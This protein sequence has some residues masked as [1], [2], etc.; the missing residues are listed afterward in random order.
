M[1]KLGLTMQ[2]ARILEWY[3][4]EGEIVERG[5]PLLSV[6]SEKVTI[7]VESPAAGVLRRILVAEMSTADVG[8]TLAIISEPNEPLPNHDVL[9]PGS[10]VQQIAQQLRRTREQT[11]PQTERKLLV[12]PAA[13][14]LADEHHLDL[15]TVAIK[16]PAEIIRER[17]VIRMIGASSA[18]AQVIP[19]SA[20]RSTM[21]ER[22]SRSYSE[23]L[24][25]TLRV[26][27]DMS[28][29]VRFKEMVSQ[30]VGQT[31]PSYTDFMVKAVALSLRNHPLF[32]STFEDGHIKTF[33]QINIGIAV[34]AQNGVAVPVVRNADRKKLAEI[35]DETNM[36]IQRARQGKLEFDDVSGGTFTVTN[37]GMY[38]VD[39]FTPIINPPQVAILAA[40]RILDKPIAIQGQ[41]SIRPMVNLTLTFDHRIADGT[42]GAEFLQT[43]C[44]IL[45]DPHSLES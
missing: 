8:E 15:S 29:L 11:R 38:G 30:E 14:R 3:F 22:L 12:S 7:D 23:A 37:L 26:E 2:Q 18:T 33:V 36:L 35:A 24:H 9:V 16:S 6:E 19:V 25:V 40:G 4:E 42:Q 21:I 13:R 45:A 39:S 28:E 1:P 44:A 32:N 43:L 41:V 20:A 27:T 5:K 17:D 10:K 34:A 31:E